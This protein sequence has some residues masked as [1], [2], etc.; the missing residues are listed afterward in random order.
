MRSRLLVAGLVAVSVALVA[1]DAWAKGAQRATV[2]GPGLEHP[3]AL[4]GQAV[5]PLIEAAGLYQ[6]VF[7]QSPPPGEPGIPVTAKRPP[8]KLGPRYVATYG[9][10]V[11][12]DRTKPVR[13]LLYPFAAG[14]ALT[15]TPPRQ[16]VFNDGQPFD[17][18]WYRAG[19]ALTTL[20]TSLGARVPSTTA[21]QRS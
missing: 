10:L 1:S 12:Q 16:R 7:H 9:W 3:V 5:Q 18:G 13:Q 8:G 14:G 11:A 21:S 20:L 2:R 4:D 6:S 15:Y 19:P 17:G